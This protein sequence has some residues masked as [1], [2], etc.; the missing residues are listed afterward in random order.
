MFKWERQLVTIANNCIC[1]DRFNILNLY[2]QLSNT[3]GDWISKKQFG[4]KDGAKFN[5]PCE[6]G[7]ILQFT[8]YADTCELKLTNPN[9][10]QNT[11]LI[12]KNDSAAKEYKVI[13]AIS[14]TFRLTNQGLGQSRPKQ[15]ASLVANMNIGD[16][17][18]FEGRNTY[19]CLNKKND[20]VTFLKVF[21]GDIANF[22]SDRLKNIEKI[23]VN[24]YSEHDWQEFYSQNRLSA[25]GLILPTLSESTA[26]QQYI[27]SL[28]GAI[29]KNQT[30]Q[31]Q[32]G[33]VNILARKKIVGKGL[34]WYIDGQKTDETVIKLLYGYFNNKPTEYDFIRTEPDNNK[35]FLDSECRTHVAMLESETKYTDIYHYLCDY[36]KEHKSDLKIDIKTYV[37]DDNGNFSAQ[38]FAFTYENEAV[39]VYGVTFENNDFKADINSIKEVSV[40]EFTNFCHKVHENN[41]MFCWQK[42]RN[43]IREIYSLDVLT[44]IQDKVAE[45]L[46]NKELQ[47][48][49]II[50][51]IKIDNTL[52]DV[53]KGYSSTIERRDNNEPTIP[54]DLFNC[55][56]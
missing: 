47:Q 10:K 14:D 1:S 36:T 44:P 31:L 50:D 39:K 6:N 18:S 51:Q 43:N 46:A 4:I 55:D 38:K 23:T 20:N 56:R 34:S 17:L 33:N 41:K 45:K 12:S 25:Y 30:K 48:I 9:T 37:P 22:T 35:T 26:A 52:D 42:H 49:S 15:M 3:A 2:L 32:W 28:Y 24:I 19:L 40:E 21:G 16:C 7:N 53:I 13:N 54:R 11:V 29:R 8:F 27:N 5:V